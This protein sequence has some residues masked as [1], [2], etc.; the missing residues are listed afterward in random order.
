MTFKQYEEKILCLQ[1]LDT[2]LILGHAHI[3]R[4]SQEQGIHVCIK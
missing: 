2:C 1:R 4:S 3:K